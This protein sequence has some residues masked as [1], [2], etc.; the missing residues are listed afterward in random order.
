MQNPVV[1]TGVYLHAPARGTLVLK[2]FHGRATEPG[3][4]VLVGFNGTDMP[5]GRVGRRVRRILMRPGSLSG[6]G[7]RSS[8]SAAIRPGTG[9]EP[10][11]APLADR[12]DYK[13]L[14]PR[15]G[16]LARPRPDENRGV[17]RGHRRCTRIRA[18]AR[19]E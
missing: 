9:V 6:F 12:S 4:L 15:L 16:T 19:A 8:E 7:E 14:P 17:R 5:T 3:A 2:A 10:I 11:V 13:D 18:G 1:S